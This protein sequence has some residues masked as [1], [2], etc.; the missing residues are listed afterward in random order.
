MLNQLYNQWGIL[1]LFFCIVVKLHFL[2]FVSVLNEVIML[3]RCTWKRLENISIWAKRKMKDWKIWFGFKTT[4]KVH[5]SLKK[6]FMTFFNLYSLILCLWV[7]EN[8]FLCF[9][10]IQIGTSQLFPK[11][12]TRLR[13]IPRNWYE[14]E[15]VKCFCIVIKQYVHKIV[16]FLFERTIMTV[17]LG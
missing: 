4:W 6:V 12:Q 3:I 1:C 13:N 8:I 9:S 14:L 17:F 11:M 16:L 7:T 10:K 2:N 5:C 15:H